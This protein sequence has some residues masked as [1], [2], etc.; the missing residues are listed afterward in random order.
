MKSWE[1]HWKDYYKILQ[2]HVSAEPEVIKAAYDKLARKYHPDVNQN[3]TA[4]ERMTDINEAFEVLS[5]PERRKQYH[6][7]WLQRT[8]TRDTSRQPAAHDG[9]KAPDRRRRISFWWILVI[10]LVVGGI[11]FVVANQSPK[12][13]TNAPPNVKIQSV[14]L[15]SINSA[16]P[17]APVYNYIFRVVNNESFDMRL[18]WEMNSSVTG[19]FDSGYITV[20]KNSYRDVT[21]SYDYFTDGMETVTYSIYYNGTL[22]DTCSSSSTQDTP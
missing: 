18:Y 7:I 20:L 17:E 11:I 4:N 6:A 1:L 3:P 5:D 16:N 10:A 15:Q 12:P 22:L 2:V 14:T 13:G 19:K 21:R 9:R 8:G